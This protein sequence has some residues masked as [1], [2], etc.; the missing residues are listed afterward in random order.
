MTA[1]ILLIFGEATFSPT[2]GK[3][4]K[5]IWWKF[6]EIK[7]SVVAQSPSQSVVSILT[8]GSRDQSFDRGEEKFKCL[9][10]LYIVSLQG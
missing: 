4:F 3:I 2:F 7:V 9:N 10:T 1:M 6:P 8:S 5:E